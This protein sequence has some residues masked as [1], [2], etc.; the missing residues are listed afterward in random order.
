M[1]LKGKKKRTIQTI[2]IKNCP[3]VKTTFFK[4][5]IRITLKK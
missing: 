5:S 2:E 4:N 3:S 1:K